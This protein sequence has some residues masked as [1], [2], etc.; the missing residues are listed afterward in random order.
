MQSKIPAWL[1]QLRMLSKVL[2][3]RHAHTLV[4][5]R[6]PEAFNAQGMMNE[7]DILKAL[8]AMPR[9]SE[10]PMDLAQHLKGLLN[11]SSTRVF[12]PEPGV[13]QFVTKNPK[14]GAIEIGGF[15]GKDAVPMT[16]IDMPDPTHPE[17][18]ITA[19]TQGQAMEQL[20]RLIK[21]GRG[22]SQRVY[23]TPG[24]VRSFEVGVTMDP[25]KWW[26]GHDIGDP[27][28]RRFT[29]LPRTINNEKISPTFTFRNSPKSNR[30]PGKDYI[31]ALLGT[32]GSKDAVLPESLRKVT[33]Y[34]DRRIGLTLDDHI[35]RV[36][37]KVLEILDELPPELVEQV[38]HRY[39]L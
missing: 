2:P 35:N 33:R 23:I 10:M 19:R 39:G 25:G 17:A 5:S 14:A 1:E 11:H 29:S 38:K 8:E 36:R 28:Y 30:A 37:P 12:K 34:H 9:G 6:G 32:L 24:G 3:S 22:R 4:P 13:V 15:H 18:G 27:F 7:Y 26:K 20:Q 31:A 16:D 21:L